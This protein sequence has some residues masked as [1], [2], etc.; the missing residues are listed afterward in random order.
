[1]GT[2]LLPLAKSI[3]YHY[4]SYRAKKIF[5]LFT[6]DLTSITEGVAGT[7]RLASVYFS[8]RQFN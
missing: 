1:M 3:Y 6:A 8:I 7:I 4:D 2:S 5:C